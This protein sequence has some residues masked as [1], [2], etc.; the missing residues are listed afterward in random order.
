MT[1]IQL[2]NTTEI[3]SNQFHKIIQLNPIQLTG[4]VAGIVTSCYV[5]LNLIKFYQFRKHHKK[6]KKYLPNR[7]K[8]QTINLS[9]LNMHH[10]NQ[11]KQQITLDHNTCLNLL[12]HSTLV[13]HKH[14]TYI[15]S[16][17]F[18][19]EYINLFGYLEYWKWIR[20]YISGQINHNPYN[21][22]ITDDYQQILTQFQ[23]F[24]CYHKFD[25]IDQ[26]IEYCQQNLELYKSIA[27]G[28][29]YEP[30]RLDIQHKANQVLLWTLLKEYQNQLQIV[31]NYQRHEHELLPEIKDKPLL[32]LLIK[33]II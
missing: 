17:V 5:T 10:P 25:T 11:L 3:I 32:H 23:A 9:W 19:Y 33:L 12:Q 15:A 28:F 30:L 20:Q 16:N 21:D 18:I 7:S 27:S 14:Q 29:E 1:F 8:S 4:L 13:D 24:K 6:I 26:V 22:Q 2:K 31:D